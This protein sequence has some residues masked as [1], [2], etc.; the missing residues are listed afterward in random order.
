MR[1]GC[2]HIKVVHHGGDGYCHGRLDGYRLP[3]DCTAYDE[4]TPKYRNIITVE[5]PDLKETAK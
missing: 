4:N 1:C 5:L 3:C 2:G